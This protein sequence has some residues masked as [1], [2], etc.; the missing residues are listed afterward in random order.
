MSIYNTSNSPNVLY[1]AL[2]SASHGDMGDGEFILNTLSIIA[3]TPLIDLPLEKDSLYL[4]IILQNAEQAFP[5]HP[6]ILK[7]LSLLK[8]IYFMDA[9]QDNFWMVDEYERVAHLKY[10]TCVALQELYDKCPEVRE[11]L[12]LP[13]INVLT[14]LGKLLPPEYEEYFEEILLQLAILSSAIGTTIGN[15]TSFIEISDA[16]RRIIAYHDYD[17]TFI[18]ASEIIRLLF[19]KP[20]EIYLASKLNIPCENACDTLLQMIIDPKH[21]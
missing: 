15:M 3:E 2:V 14:V 21:D 5:E 17:D 12:R 10:N 7:S 20:Y 8:L 9:K 13:A 1:N 18:A 11:I 6:E 16:C 4:N 19:I